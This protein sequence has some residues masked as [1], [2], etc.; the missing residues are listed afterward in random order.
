VKRT[1]PREAFPCA[2]CQAEG[3]GLV[4]DSR[5]TWQGLAIRRRRVCPACG[6][7]FTTYE[8]TRA[9][10]DSSPDVAPREENGTLATVTVPARVLAKRRT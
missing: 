1:R 9:D 6:E 4:V 3:P 8:M 10:T 7:S 5:P 2:R